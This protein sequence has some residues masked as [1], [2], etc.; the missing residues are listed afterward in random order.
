M[1]IAEITGIPA[2]EEIRL[3]EQNFGKFEGTSPRKAPEFVAAKSQ[4]AIS[5]EGGES[6][7]KLAQRIYNLLDEL[8]YDDKIY[9]LVAHN[10]IARVVKSYFSDMTNEEYSN[11]GV[12][13]SEL[14][15][16]KYL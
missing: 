15:E 12:P 14:I 7:M 9:M 5:Y 3:I 6:M 16:F 13:N 10:G 11:F 8:E 1:H 2:K 4:F